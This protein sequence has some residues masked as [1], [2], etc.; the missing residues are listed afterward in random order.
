MKTLIT[1]KEVVALAFPASLDPEGSFVTESAIVAAQQ[2]FI[3]PVFNKLYDTID[4]HPELLA[5]FVK[6]ALAQWVRYLILPSIASQVGSVG[7]IAP[8][9]QNFESV[10]PASVATLRARAKADARALTR[11]AVEHVEANAALF[12][13]YDSSLNILNTVKTTGNVIL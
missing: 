6:P 10:A 9:G 5:D 7:I 12:H 13:H 3:K 8:R 4:T 2:K 1:P 11:R